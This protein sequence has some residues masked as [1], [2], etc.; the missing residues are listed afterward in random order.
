MNIK[1]LNVFIL[2]LTFAKLLNFEAVELDEIDVKIE[3]CT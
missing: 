1:L 3:D 2:I